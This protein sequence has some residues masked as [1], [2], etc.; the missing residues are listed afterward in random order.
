MKGSKE[1]GVPPMS[2]DLIELLDKK[3]QVP[4]MA[5]NM[6]ASEERRYEYAKKLGRRELIDKLKRQMEGGKTNG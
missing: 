4:V 1:E 5:P 3:E 2:K 6:L